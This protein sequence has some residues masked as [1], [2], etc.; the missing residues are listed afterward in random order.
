MYIKQ[1]EYVIINKFPDSPRQMLLRLNFMP[2]T[3]KQMR[4]KFQILIIYHFSVLGLSMHLK[5][6][7]KTV[8]MD[9]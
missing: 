6:A 8:F 4:K 7:V 2:E 9:S 3:F 1:H 5:T